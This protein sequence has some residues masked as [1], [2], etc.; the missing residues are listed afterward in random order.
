MDSGAEARST[1]P[2]AESLLV[3]E[4]RASQSRLELALSQISEGLVICDQAG[5][6]QWCNAAFERLIQRSRLQLLGCSLPD[7]MSGL[8]PDEE[9]LDVRLLLETRQGKSFS[10]LASRDPL[11]VLEI[12]CQP[13]PSDA[14]GS[15]IFGFRDVSDRVS[16]EELRLRSEEILVRQLALA[17]EVKTCPV[18]GLPNRRGLLEAVNQSLE[19]QRN[20]GGWIGL[21]F[22]DLNRFK[23]VNDTYG[24]EVGDQLLIEL[25]QRMRQVLRPN[26]LLARLGGDEFVL[27]LDGLETPDE[28]M[29]VAQRLRDAV[30]M[31]WRPRRS[32]AEFEIN[33]ELSI[34][35]SVADQPVRS[36]DELLHDADLAMYEAKAGKSA[37]IVVF[38]EGIKLRLQRRIRIRTLLQRCLRQRAIEV[39]LQPVVQL[40]DGRSVGFEALLQPME[41]DGLKILPQDLIS[42]AESS[43]LIVPLGQLL[44]E[45]SLSSVAGID[46]SLYPHGLA[47]NVSPLQLV[48]VGLAKRILAEV[49]RHDFPPGWVCI[50]ITETALIDNPERAREEISLLRQ[51]GCRVVLDD[52]G[53]GYSSLT[54]LAELPIDGLKIDRS[55]IASMATDERRCQL[56]SGILGLAQLL[57]LEVIAEGI[58][59]AVLSEQLQAMDCTFGQGYYF[60]PPLRPERLLE[61]PLLLPASRS[62]L[63]RSSGFPPAAC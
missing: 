27:L 30:S 47:I 56:V 18:T 29:L 20:E 36:A 35:I 24:H 26:D 57:G 55:F 12:E 28:A 52:F 22:C 32:A 33:P 10:A 31:P 44:L 8:L 19:R 41:M 9:R 39:L 16:L 43:G 23:E 62:P 37:S 46:Y 3:R 63:T 13:V 17:A 4:L 58:E 59:T 61:L 45:V 1:A 2:A 38:D 60:S 7:L 15:M 25:A 34:G 21:L 11:R 54:W 51:G 40:S 50:E 42:V 48:S 53:T 5:S 14:S 49:S 6:L